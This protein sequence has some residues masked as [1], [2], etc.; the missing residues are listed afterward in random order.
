MHT[1]SPLTDTQAVIYYIIDLTPVIFIEIRIEIGLLDVSLLKHPNSNLLHCTQCII[2]H[3][4]TEIA[5]CIK[6]TFL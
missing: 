6:A 5:F 1:I 4:S 3:C 2:L